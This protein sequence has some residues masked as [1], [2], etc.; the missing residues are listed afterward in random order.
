MVLFFSFFFFLFFFFFRLL[1]FRK[2]PQN[3][4]ASIFLLAPLIL[5]LL[6][7]GFCFLSKLQFSHKWYIKKVKKNGLRIII[8]I[9]QNRIDIKGSL[10][11]CY[12]DLCQ[13]KFPKE[14]WFQAEA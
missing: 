3:E 14:R 1:I 9:M 13:E 12:N 11:D 5:Y 4:A 7:N 10:V 8:K 2:S 6:Q